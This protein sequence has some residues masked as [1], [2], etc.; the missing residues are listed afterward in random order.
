MDAITKIYLLLHGRIKCAGI[1]III[2]SKFA[3]MEICKGKRHTHFVSM[4][5][6]RICG[7]ESI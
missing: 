2:E 1:W 3:S 6:F 4:H 7:F 5:V